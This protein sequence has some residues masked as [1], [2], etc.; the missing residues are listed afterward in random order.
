MSRGHGQMERAVLA[1]IPSSAKRTTA[2]LRLQIARYQNSY[3]I[4]AKS[5]RSSLNRA[6]RN[7]ESAGKIKRTTLEVD[8]VKL[9]GWCLPSMT[10]RR[11]EVA[12]HEAG[13]AVIGHELDR[14]VETATIKPDKG[15]LGRVT[16]DWFRQIDDYTNDILCSMAGAIAESEFTGQP[17]EWSAPNLRTDLQN[18]RY[19]KKCLEK[20]GH[21]VHPDSY[22]EEQT[23]KLVREHW[24]KIE[25][26]AEALLK[27]ET[28]TRIELR[29]LLR[30]YG[31]VR[32]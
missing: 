22:Y 21:E 17:F 15:Y 23:R 13:H 6:L 2:Q 9:Q 10:A 31:R 1:R 32:V 28:L 20:A 26:L 11:K 14:A 3:D 29:E 5:F 7:L 27:K 30:K 8:G 19:A 16:H 18:I 24:R 4:D 25:A 12:F